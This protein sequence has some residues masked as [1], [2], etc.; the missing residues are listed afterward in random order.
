MTKFGPAIA[1]VTTIVVAVVALGFLVNTPETGG[2]IALPADGADVAPGAYSVDVDGYRYTFRVPASGWK[3]K[4]AAPNPAFG[5]H[6][7]GLADVELTLGDA[8][9]DPPDLAVFGLRGNVRGISAPPCQELF[10]GGELGPGDD[11]AAVAADLAGL[12]GFT[13]TAPAD[14]TVAGYAG[15]HLELTVRSDVWC[16]KIGSFSDEDGNGPDYVAP[17]QIE[18]IWVLEVEHG[19]WRVF[20]ITYLPTTPRERVDELRQMVESLAIE[21]AVP[22]SPTPA[23]ALPATERFDSPV[24]GISFNYPSGWQVRAA[25]EP[26]T[27]GEVNFDSPG[28]DVIFDPTL[29]D[30]LYLAAV[31][32]PSDGQSL[33][34]L[35]N[36]LRNALPEICTGSDG[37]GGDDSDGEY[38]VGDTPVMLAF[39]R[40]G[41]RGAGRDI[42]VIATPTRGYLVWLHL[43]AVGDERLQETYGNGW[44]FAVVDSIR[45]HANEALDTPTPSESP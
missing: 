39:M 30:D 31:S 28:V 15:K 18:E 40:C 17:D 20:D 11:V 25:A 21:P 37:P 14:V 6:A 29:G 16:G 19:R 26:W 36:E 5:D 3:V 12:T 35:Y 43:G 27:G 42:A 44:F 24:H 34:E 10:G 4:L 1:G 9:N 32:K 41:S 2:P 7:P 22:P 13:A 33:D 23:P 38:N 45:P 8:T